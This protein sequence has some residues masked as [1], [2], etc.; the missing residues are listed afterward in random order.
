MMNLNKKSKKKRIEP[1][2]QGIINK[3]LFEA[4]EK[5]HEKEINELQG[6]DVFD[7]PIQPLI[8]KKAKSENLAAKR[9]SENAKNNE[10]T[11]YI[12]CPIPKI[13]I[14]KV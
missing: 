7:L 6:E 9:N 5:E 10:L 1:S 11:N 12:K 14:E 13:N 3:I 2:K 8:R 4:T